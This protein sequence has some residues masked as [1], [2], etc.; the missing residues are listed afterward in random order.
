MLCHL[1]QHFVSLLIAYKS[2]EIVSK[3]SVLC[4]DSALVLINVRTNLT[5][6]NQGFFFFICALFLVIMIFV[7][8]AT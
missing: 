8:I 2:Y 1:K 5:A 6:V 7:F 4:F 3:L